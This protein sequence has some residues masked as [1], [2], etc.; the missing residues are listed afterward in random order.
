MI[1]WITEINDKYLNFMNSSSIWIWRIF[2][3]EMKILREY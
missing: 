3:I 1:V 2:V